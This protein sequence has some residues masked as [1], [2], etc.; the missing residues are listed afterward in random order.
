MVIVTRLNPGW[1]VAAA[2]TI[3]LALVALAGAA[4]AFAETSS[5]WS[6]AVELGVPAEAAATGGAT[7]LSVSCAA[8]GS[9][10]AVGSYEVDATHRLPMAISK[11]D[12]TWQPAL[13]ITLPA[14]ADTYQQNARLEQ[15]SCSAP[16]YCA[17]IGMYED[18]RG[19]YQAMA[20]SELA[21]SWASA[22]E[23]GLPEGAE[24]RSLGIERLFSSISCSGPVDCAAVGQYYEGGNEK[25]RAMFATSVNGV[26]QSGATRAQLPEPTAE[27]PGANLT[28]VSCWAPG[29]CSA[30]GYY[31]PLATPTTWRALVIGENGG[32]WT[33]A[34]QPP[35]P[36]GR[37]VEQDELVSVI[38]F[39]PGNCD[40]TGALRDEVYAYGMAARERNGVWQQ[41]VELV[42]PPGTPYELTADLSQLACSGEE[43]CV[44]AGYRGK[45]ETLLTA[46]S[47]GKWGSE[48]LL[49]IPGSPERP[50]SKIAGIAC[51]PAAFCT[52]IGEYEEPG[53]V[54][55][56]MLVIANAGVWNTSPSGVTLPPDATAGGSLNAISCSAGGNCDAV[57][58]F[59]SGAAPGNSRPMA[60]SLGEPPAPA[61]SGPH[62]VVVPM[63]KKSSL[64]VL[65]SVR[66]GDLLLRL[67]GPLRCS[68][69]GKRMSLKLTAT[70]AS[71]RHPAAF[72]V[73]HVSLFIDGGRRTRA[74]VGKGRHRR[75]VVLYRPQFQSARPT[76]FSFAPA[77]IHAHR[78]RNKVTAVVTLA[79]YRVVHHRRIRH[80][81]TKRLRASFSVC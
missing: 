5:P 15:V 20:V 4:P 79:R 34:S 39:G 11:Q 13:K 30:V 59:A 32:A 26:W 46:F 1:Y 60:I 2:G 7:L 44:A 36:A 72:K 47:A 63:S 58:G 28:S 3:A 17:A 22:S 48:E 70:Y 24:Q 6:A 51:T 67:L 14:N 75:R 16:G 61:G 38:C 12:S 45:E 33:A 31:K 69:S 37:R 65:A 81:I 42:P 19:E 64:A 25:R 77:R 56:S 57:G 23:V 43:A 54:R 35:L 41:G 40:A 9:C 49:L 27:E 55:R 21:G 50:E 8:A 76:T 68:A 53:E 62:P 74:L 80:V 10:G 66:I 78:G 18:S 52:A 73:M 71:T 29:S